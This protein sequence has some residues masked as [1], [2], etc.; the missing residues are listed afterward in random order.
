MKLNLLTKGNLKISKTVGIFDLPTSVCRSSCEKC[1]AKKAE[2]MYKNV[3]PKRNRNLEATLRDSFIEEM[4]NEITISKIKAFR[5][6]SSGDFYSQDYIDKWIK[7][8]NKHPDI[9]FYAYT[10]AKGYKDLSFKKIEKLKN[11]N[12]I[13]SVTPLGVNY[14]SKE[15]CD[16]LVKEYG[17]TL[18]PC[19]PGKH[20]SCGDECT[21]CVEKNKM[22]CFLQH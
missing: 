22:I 18:C 21:L 2:K 7:I 9:K 19:A 12:L 1:Y 16:K 11:F 20:V 15:Y 8:I 13:N 5:L 4:S 6:H 17:Y 14:G 10:K 3:L